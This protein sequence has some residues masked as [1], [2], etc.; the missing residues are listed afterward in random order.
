MAD[1]LKDPFE[2]FNAPK[3]AFRAWRAARNTKLEFVVVNVHIC[4]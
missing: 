4:R 2:T 1:V 3:G